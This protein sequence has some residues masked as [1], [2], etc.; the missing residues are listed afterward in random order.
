MPDT[1]KLARTHG[2]AP[3]SER[4]DGKQQQII[5]HTHKI[6]GRDGAMT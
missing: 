4:A 2:N 1:Q 6:H 5:V 3:R